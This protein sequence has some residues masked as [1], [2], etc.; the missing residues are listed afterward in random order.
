MPDESGNM[1]V[2]EESAMNIALE[3]GADDVVVNDDGTWSILGSGLYK[4][5][6][7]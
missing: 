1:S 6:A 7:I 5:F 3:A 2:D 4:A